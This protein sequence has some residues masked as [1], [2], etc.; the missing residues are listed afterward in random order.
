MRR[1]ARSGGRP[2]KAWSAR[3]CNYMLGA[4]SQVLSQLV[5]EGRLIRNVASLVDR[6]PSNAK[7]LQTFTPDQVQIVLRGIANDRNRHAWHLALAGLRRGEIAGQ[8]WVDI[9]LE[10]NTA[11]R[12][13]PSGCRR[14]C[15]RPGRAQDRQ[16]VGYCRYRMRSSPNSLKRETARPPRSWPWATHIPTRATWSATRL[17]S[18]TTPRR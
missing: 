17:A 16:P 6:V 3:S 15:P 18:P 7:K 1:V 4:L 5:A 13:D 11:D 14:P 9:D 8:R 10:P 12:C 2:R